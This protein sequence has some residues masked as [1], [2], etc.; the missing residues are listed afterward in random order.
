[1]TYNLTGIHSSTTISTLFTETNTLASG[2][3][4]TLFILGIFFVFLMVLL[5]RGYDFPIV[6]LSVS[7][8]CFTISAI[9]SWASYVNIIMPL[10]FLAV[11]AFTSLYLFTIGSK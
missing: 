5:R 7:T 1:M 9:A 8:I 3:L 2:W 6:L 4:F 10:A 11:S